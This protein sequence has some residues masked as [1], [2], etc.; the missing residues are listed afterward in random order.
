MVEKVS[1]MCPSFIFYFFPHVKNWQKNGEC[2]D[3]EFLSDKLYFGARRAGETLVF[4][5]EP[6]QMLCCNYLF[7]MLLMVSFMSLF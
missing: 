3:I 6:V 5:C 7:R 2:C 1:R 4:V